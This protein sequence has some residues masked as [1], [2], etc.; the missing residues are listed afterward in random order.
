M[1]TQNQSQVAL[2]TIDYQIH[3]NSLITIRWRTGIYFVHGRMTEN[4]ILIRDSD[5]HQVAL[6]R[7]IPSQALQNHSLYFGW[8]THFEVSLFLQAKKSFFE[9]RAHILMTSRTIADVIHPFTLPHPSRTASI[10]RYSD[11]RITSHTQ[12]GKVS[13]APHD[14]AT[15]LAL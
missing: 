4:I 7:G 5:S 14:M 8:R 9:I 6:T 12:V 1:S 10:S 15:R 13:I 3:L 2:K 11:W